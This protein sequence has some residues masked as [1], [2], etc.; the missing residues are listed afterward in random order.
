MVNL[1]NF[2]ADN[3]SKR[4]AIFTFVAAEKKWDTS[5]VFR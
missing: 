1:S 5:E 4:L 3:V 2:R